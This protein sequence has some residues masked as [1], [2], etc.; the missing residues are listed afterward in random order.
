MTED[1]TLSAAALIRGLAE[2]GAD[3][4]LDLL[5]QAIARWP[6]VGDAIL[7]GIAQARDAETPEDDALALC[8]IYLAAHLRDGRALPLLCT[9][10]SREEGLMDIIGDGTT[11][12]FPAILVRLYDG[13]PA[14][15]RMV[16]EAE[17]AD[18]FLRAG[19]LTAMAWLT[20]E[21]RIERDATIAYLSWLHEHGQPKGGNYL[22]TAWA[23]TAALLGPADM[24]T[25]VEEAFLEG[26]IDETMVTVEEIQHIHATA[27]A[28]GD[29]F[30]AL[31]P[32]LGTR[33]AE[34]DDLLAFVAEWKTATPE[35]AAPNVYD[36][37]DE[38]PGHGR[39]IVS[40]G[41]YHNPYRNVGRN[42]PCPCGSGKKFKKC[43]LGVAG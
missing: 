27:M 30:A 6:E 42:D 12:D 23:S 37:D 41:T 8:A 11:M 36:F 26:R 13:D 33:I 7:L 3:L 1:T 28:G 34:M 25:L 15:L 2:C 16:I 31:D 4:P 43:C 20:L 5:G 9:L 21:G 10:A 17:Q 38:E 24:L 35:A 14:P 29:L 39:V 32:H 22:W 40:E 19:A 18:E